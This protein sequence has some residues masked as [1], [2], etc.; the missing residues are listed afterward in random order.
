VFTLAR[1]SA[2]VSMKVG[3]VFQQE[4]RPHIRLRERDRKHHVMPCHHH[5][6]E[7]YLLASVEAAAFRQELRPTPSESRK[8]EQYFSTKSANPLELL[9]YDLHE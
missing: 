4:K 1:V 2:A 3:D 6:L 8:C 5:E 9:E 7:D